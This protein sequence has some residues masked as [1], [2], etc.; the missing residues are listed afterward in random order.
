MAWPCLGSFGFRKALV[1]SGWADSLF[2]Y[3]NRLREQASHFVGPP[4]LALMVFHHLDRWL[5]AV[6]TYCL[7]PTN[8]GLWLVTNVHRIAA[9]ALG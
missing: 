4:F 2:L 3:T 8:K 7:D 6:G 5:L 1:G 9:R